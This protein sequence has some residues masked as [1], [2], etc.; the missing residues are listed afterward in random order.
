M[1]APIGFTVGLNVA[2]RDHATWEADIAAA[3]DVGATCIRTGLSFWDLDAA[4][5]K[6]WARARFQYARDR[7]LRIM[8]TLAQLVGNDPAAT[9]ATAV[10][11]AIANGAMAYDVVDGVVEWVQVLN[12]WDGSDWRDWDRKL[13]PDVAQDGQPPRPGVD[14]EYLR[15]VHDVIEGVRAHIHAK[16]PSV[17]VG[18][19]TTGVTMDGGSELLWRRMYDTVAPACDYI[20]LN[21]YPIKWAAQYRMMPARTRRTG[22][23]YRLPVVMTEIGLPSSTGTTQGEQGERIAHMAI[24]ASVDAGVLG[25]FLYQLRDTGTDPA[26]AEQCFGI[27]KH[28]GTRKSGYRTVRYALWSLRGDLPEDLTN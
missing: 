22:G 19:A 28:D 4:D 1:R 10:P 7:G 18:T 8:L 5:S 9:N 16:R 2:G 13:G 15:G 11:A 12:E 25:V 24:R 14:A 6:A 26:D 17:L 23:R 20:G 3:L 27:L 21:G